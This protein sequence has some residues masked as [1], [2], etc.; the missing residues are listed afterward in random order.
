VERAKEM[1]KCE[2]CGKRIWFWQRIGFNTSWHKWCTDSWNKGYS[3]AMEIAQRFNRYKNYDDPWNMA[4]MMT[5]STSGEAKT[6]L[7]PM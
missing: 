3:S 5:C 4:Q 2:G 1:I 7:K 6:N